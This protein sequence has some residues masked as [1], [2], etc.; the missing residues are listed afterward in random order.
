VLV[1]ELPGPA[2]SV[3]RAPVNAPVPPETGI[4]IFTPSRAVQPLMLIVPPGRLATPEMQP[5]FR[6]LSEIS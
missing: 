4:G 2:V 3:P 6:R 1:G 5:E